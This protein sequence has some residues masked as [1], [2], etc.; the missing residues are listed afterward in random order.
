[1][2]EEFIFLNDD[3]VI[4]EDENVKPW[5]ILIVDDEPDVH[6]ATKFSLAMIKIKGRPLYFLDAYTGKEAKQIVEERDDID[7]MLLDAIMETPTAG[8]D[9]A[10][11]CKDTLGKRIPIIVMRS[12]FAGA[13]VEARIDD[14]C[15]L[16]AF[17]R[18]TDASKDKLIEV[19]TEY[20]GEGSEGC[21]I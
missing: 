21:V 5:N 6:N 15:C 13:M 8:L 3:E 12:G 20:L 16:D 19:L 9:C 7:L 10:C 1:M 14:H 17:L 2:S 11:Y 18:K 4:F